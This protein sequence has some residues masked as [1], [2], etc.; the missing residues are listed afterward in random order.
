[1]VSF[2]ATRPV[3]PAG[4]ASPVISAAQLWAGLEYKAR[5][6][7]RFVPQIT[8]CR[9]VHQ[10]EGKLTR[11]VRFGDSSPE[12]KE[13][14]QFF[15]NTIVYFEMSPVEPLAPSSSPSTTPVRITNL[16]SYGPPPSNDL[17]LSF[18]FAPRMPHVGDD[19]ARGM[20]DAEL[21][22]RVGKGVEGTIDLIR[23]MVRDGEL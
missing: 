5:N 10:D 13:E 6:P 1:M 19:E 15:P 12:M 20:S 14:V 3:N 23:K 9:I 16:V 22:E 4:A 17:L 8:A 7:E 18:S 2:A 21:N 11:I